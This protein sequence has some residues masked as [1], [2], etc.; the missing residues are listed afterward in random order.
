MTTSPAA[1]ERPPP[2][3][4]GT[5]AGEG[6]I[7]GRGPLRWL[8][9][10]EP[11]EISTRFERL[12]P[13]VWVVRDDLRFRRGGGMRRTMFLER[14]APNRYHVT[15]DDM[16]L[17]SDVEVT[18]GG[19]RY[20]PYWSWASLRGR[21]WFVRVHEEGTFSPDRIEARMRVRWRGI[22]VSRNDLVLRRV[23]P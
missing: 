6:Q 9:P 12:S 5:W 8:V 18:D 1:P 19:Y 13:S 7:V 14:I 4:E 15:A 3:F 2:F 11:Y 21:R 20:A 10:R 16:P 22:P 17:G 23:F